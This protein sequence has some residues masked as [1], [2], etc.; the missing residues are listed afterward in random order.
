[1]ALGIA[2]SPFAG[3]GSGSGSQAHSLA[4]AGPSFAKLIHSSVSVWSSWALGDFDPHSPCSVSPV[5]ILLSLHPLP[6]C[7]DRGGGGGGG[8]CGGRDAAARWLVGR[9]RTSAEILRQHQQG[10]RL[11]QGPRVQPHPQHAV[12]PGLQIRRGLQAWRFVHVCARR[13]RRGFSATPPAAS[14]GEC[15]APP[16]APCS[17]LIPCRD[18]VICIIILGKLSCYILGE[19][20]LSSHL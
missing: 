11:P 2:A 16:Y 10:G 3:S 5:L 1:M 8:S 20:S 12:L 13:P 17:L 14:A 19:A 9:R 18:A 7:S 15:R 6:S 4:L